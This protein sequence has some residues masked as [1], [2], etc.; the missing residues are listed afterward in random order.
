MGIFLANYDIR[1]YA[2]MHGVQQYRI[3]EVMGVSPSHLSVVLRKELTV[4][5]KEE[6]RKI[7]DRISADLYGA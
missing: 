5:E 4:A 1:N 2:R 7:I 3:A 6:I